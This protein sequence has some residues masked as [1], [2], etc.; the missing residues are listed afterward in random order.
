MPRVHPFSL[1][2]LWLDA[3]RHDYSFSF[4]SKKVRANDTISSPK[5]TFAKL[6]IRSEFCEAK[7][8]LGSPLPPFAEATKSQ[9]SPQCMETVFSFILELETIFFKNYFHS[10]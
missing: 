9:S 3:R 2:T 6:E 1:D 5:D 7:L 4:R 10:K 8:A